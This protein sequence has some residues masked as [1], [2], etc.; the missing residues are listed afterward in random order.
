MAGLAEGLAMSA[1]FGSG[2]FLGCEGGI[3][4]YEGVKDSVGK[5]C[6]VVVQVVSCCVFNVNM[7]SFD[8]V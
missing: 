7:E 5:D 8:G 1:V 3:K 6:M 4:F 2:Q